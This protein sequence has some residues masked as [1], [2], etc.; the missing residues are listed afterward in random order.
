MTRVAS[1]G[2]AKGRRPKACPCGSGARYA[3]CCQPYHAGG[4]AE[5]PERLMR[6]RFAAFALGDGAYLLRTT[7][8]GHPLSLRPPDEAI[9]ELS[10]ARQRL[11]YLDLTV[12]DARE[13]GDRGQVLFTAR[14][15]ERGRDVSFTELSD[16]ERVDG[17]WRYLDGLT[18][19]ALDAP[20]DS[21]DAFL[22][23]LE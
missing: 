6:S 16:F 10:T 8:P 1:S 18:A 15:F 23:R 4:E 7:H 11:R 5:T 2:M 20:P 3:S 19:P 13:D 22:E 9:R 12:H 14:V 21:I 17:A